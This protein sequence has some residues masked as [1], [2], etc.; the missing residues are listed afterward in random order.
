MLFVYPSDCFYDFGSR[1]TTGTESHSTFLYIG[2]GNIQFDGRDV[3]QGVD[4]FCS[5]RIISDGRPGNIYQNIRFDIL[6]FRINT[7]DEI[8]DPFILQADCIQHTGRGFSHTGIGIPF[9]VF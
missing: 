4:F 8:I 2:T 7:F 1:S 3:I 6:Y 5:L 9:A